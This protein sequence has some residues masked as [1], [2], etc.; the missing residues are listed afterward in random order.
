MF[1]YTIYF[2]LYISCIIIIII[3]TE[4]KL[5]VFI[6]KQYLDKLCWEY[7][8]SN[9]IKSVTNC[10]YLNI[11]LNY[12]VSFFVLFVC[13]NFSIYKIP[14][15]THTHWSRYIFSYLNVKNTYNLCNNK[16]T[17]RI[18]ISFPVTK[19]WSCKKCRW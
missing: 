1:Y 10:E 7:L 14:L 17:N 2:K 13:F 5:V 6:F 16:A 9:P 3:T 12:F 8:L 19:Q 18:D 15:Y 4:V 11:N